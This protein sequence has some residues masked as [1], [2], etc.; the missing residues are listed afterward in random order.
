MLWTVLVTALL[1]ILAIL[2]TV[3]VTA[4]L[5]KLFLLQHFCLCCGLFLLAAYIRLATFTVSYR[6]TFLL[7]DW[8]VLLAAICFSGLMVG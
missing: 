1:A 8:F 5:A 2:W 7:S 4:L 3:L 6:L